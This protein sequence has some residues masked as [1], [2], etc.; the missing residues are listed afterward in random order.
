MALVRRTTL[1]GRPVMAPPAP[2]SMAVPRQPS[3]AD[4]DD[5][6]AAAT[7]ASVG[8]NDEM[9]A[10]PD[11]PARLWAIGVGLV[12]AAAG[13]AVALIIDQNHGIPTMPITNE[14]AAIMSLLL[15]A[16]V[17]ERLLEPF[18]RWMPG[19]RARNRYEQQVADLANR[20]PDVTLASVAAAR[21][22]VEQHRAEKAMLAWGLATA[23]AIIMAAA[24]GFH[25]LR[26][27]VIT[28]PTWEVVPV[29][30]DAVVTGLIVGSGT[31]PLHDLFT[32]LRQGNAQQRDPAAA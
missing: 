8:D 16:T 1:E 18:T 19:R 17:V 32:R 10:A 2:A 4:I 26:I 31:K 13:A 29:W 7:A 24:G 15:F 30:V 23:V 28:D 11:R 6:A 22:R 9:A 12:F 25:L 14:A 20:H 3:A 27:L 5:V 21:A